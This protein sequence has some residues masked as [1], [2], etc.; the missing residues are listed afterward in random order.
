M[1]RGPA[2]ARRVP[3]P[4]TDSR[5]R[6]GPGLTRTAGRWKGGGIQKA[7][8]VEN[9]DL[10]E[11]QFVPKHLPC[12]GVIYKFWDFLFA[13]GGPAS[14]QAA[15]C[16][17]PRPGRVIAARLAGP[18]VPGPRWALKFPGFR[19]RQQEPVTAGLLEP[20]SSFHWVGGGVRSWSCLK[21]RLSAVS[22][23]RAARLVL[24]HQGGEKE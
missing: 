16:S 13:A 4:V 17:A 12:N 1:G 8:L 23:L 21:E 2:A 15:L 3:L 14:G 19:A 5:W 24:R 10:K 20:C 9:K 11:E 18:C 6:C 7:K 22:S